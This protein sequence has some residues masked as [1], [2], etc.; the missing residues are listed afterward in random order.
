[1]LSIYVLIISLCRVLAD[2]MIFNLCIA[3]FLLFPF[4]GDGVEWEVA[5]AEPLLL[6]HLSF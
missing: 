1:M 2:V 6:L 4:M 5:A 3:G